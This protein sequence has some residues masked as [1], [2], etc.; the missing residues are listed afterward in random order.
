MLVSRRANFYFAD[1]SINFFVVQVRVCHDDS[2]Y[3]SYTEIPIEC[4]SQ[5]LSYTLVQVPNNPPIH[6]PV[7]LPA[8]LELNCILLQAAF[9]GKPGSDLAAEL[10]VTAQ[11]DV[12]FA[13]FR[14][15]LHPS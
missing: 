6:L 11:D 15:L 14:L 5:G 9:V 1:T 2:D 8:Y 7:H 10:G 4:V 13:V 12:L 3:Y